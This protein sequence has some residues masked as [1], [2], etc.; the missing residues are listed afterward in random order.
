METTKAERSV[1]SPLAL[2]LWQL[3]A[4]TNR[5]ILT[6]SYPIKAPRLKFHRR[7]AAHHA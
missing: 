5:D 2:L 1:R 7:R 4:V 3:G 6:Y